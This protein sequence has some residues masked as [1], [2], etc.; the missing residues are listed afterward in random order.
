MSKHPSAAAAR[1]ESRGARRFWLGAAL[2]F[3]LG[4]TATFAALLGVGTWA[5]GLAQRGGASA[6][7]PPARLS[8][9]GWV[10]GLDGRRLELRALAGRAAVVH[11]WATWCGPCRRELPRV[12]ALAES[13]A[14]DGIAF[15]AVTDEDPRR[16]RAYLAGRGL[17]LPAYVARAPLPP[18]LRAPA[19]PATFVVAPDGAVVA[20]HV[21]AGG[22]DR[23]AVHRGLREGR[24]SAPRP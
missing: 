19:L 21:G 5:A 13:L 6:P 12:A 20:R 16:V 8:Y 7:G 10:E 15:L 9:R 23:A 4:S 22:W 11:R 24:S 14:A 1:P 17:R 3:A 18:Q 2:G